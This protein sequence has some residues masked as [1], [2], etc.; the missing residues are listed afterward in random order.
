MKIIKKF[1]L[2]NFILLILLSNVK[3]QY[4]NFNSFSPFNIRAL[5]NDDSIDKYTKKILLS[6]ED[7]ISNLLS[8][9]IYNVS[10]NPNEDDNFKEEAT[11]CLQSYDIFYNK[12]DENA[13][14]YYLYLLYYDSSKSKNDLGSYNDCMNKQTVP[15]SDLKISEERKKELEKDSTFIVFQVHEKKNNS[16]ANINYQENEYLVG[17]CIKKGCSENVLKKVL[18]RVNQE[19]TFFE[20]FTND[21]I[22][23]YDLDNSKY[24]VKDYWFHCIPSFIIF[25]F[26]LFSCFKFFPNK[27]FSLM[28]ARRYNQM[29][30]C[31]NLKNNHE[32]IFGNYQEN[33]NIVSNDTGLSIIKGLRGLNMIAVLLSTSFFYIYHLP[34]KIYSKDTFKVFIKSINFSSIYY[35]NRFGIKILYSMSGFE[36]VYKMLNYLD[37]CIENKEKL[38]LCNED[39]DEED[40]NFLKNNDEKNFDD[41]SNLQKKKE[42]NEKIVN[43]LSLKEK[44]NIQCDEENEEEEEEEK[45]DDYDQEKIIDEILSKDNNKSKGSKKGSLKSKKNEKNEN[46][47]ERKKTEEIKEN[48]FTDFKNIDLRNEDEVSKLQSINKILYKRHREKLETKILYKF[49]LKQ[50][51]RYF[52]FIFTIIFYKYGFIKSLLAIFSPSP[53]W[54]IYIRQISDKFTLSQIFANIFCYSPFSYTTYNAVDPFG[55]IYNEIIFFLI[56][57]FLIFFCYKYCKRLDLYIIYLSIFF[58]LVKV[59]IGSYYIFFNEENKDFN[60]VNYKKSNHGFYPLMFYQYNEENLRVKSFLFSNQFFNMPFFLLGILFGEMNYC[61]QNFSKAKDKNKQYLTL[62][63]KALNCFSKIKK[64]NI[65]Y[66]LVFLVLFSLCVFTYQF[67]IS[68]CEDL[69]DPQQFFLNPFYNFIGLIDTDIGIVFYFLCIIILLLSEDNIL[70]NFLRHKYWGIL[71]RTY[72]TFLLCLHICSSFVFYLSENRIKLIFY[73]VLF[74]SFEIL[75]IVVIMVKINFICVEIP[76]KKIN[77]IFIKNEDDILLGHK[78]K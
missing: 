35:G 73:N 8:F 67:L 39:D 47:I 17:L 29:K 7:L 2:L 27:L 38:N 36:L 74:F 66:F 59:G 34:T 22:E 41:N 60:D 61:I 71:S 14:H 12:K 16:F 15:L 52:M 10:K 64:A 18:A 24:K 70:V 51:H 78:N 58:F 68:K 46:N 77:K 40:L 6:V 31:F 37:N 62:A 63:K 53:M 56:G 28:N 69:E 49:I 9:S 5:S 11:K 25:L 26:I 48:F 45:E 50:W 44:K 21:D 75:I 43:M 3:T 30:E 65:F 33:S 1:R 32:E 42:K 19:I 23:V 20:N 72:W 13:R 57:S 76:L 54:I 4:F 55:M